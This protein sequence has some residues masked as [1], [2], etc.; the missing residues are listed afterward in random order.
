MHFKLALWAII[1]K[2]SQLS[3]ALNDPSSKYNNT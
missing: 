3:S 1:I 2:T